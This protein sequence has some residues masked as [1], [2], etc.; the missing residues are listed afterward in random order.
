MWDREG[1]SDLVAG[2]AEL[3]S[4]QAA[5]LRGGR[6][7]ALAG[8]VPPPSCAALAGPLAGV[9]GGGASRSPGR[10]AQDPPTL[11]RPRRALRPLPRPL[12]RDLRDRALRDLDPTLA[13][14]ARL[15]RD[16]RDDVRRRRPRRPAGARRSPAARR[17][18][19][20][21]GP[22]SAAPGPSSL[23]AGVAAT[24]FGLLYGEFFGPT[25]VVPVLW[26]APLEEPV[27]LLAAGARRGRGAARRRPTSSARSTGGARAAGRCAL[28]AA[29]GIAGAALF[30]GLGAR[31]CS[32]SSW[33]AP[34][35]SSLGALVAGTRG[36][37]GLRRVPRG[38]RRRRRR[39][40]AG[41]DRAVR[42][43]PPAR[44][45]PRVLRPARGVRPDPRR[46]RADRVGRDRRACGA[47]AAPGCRPRSP[48][49]W[50]ATPS[51]SPS[52]RWWPACRPSGWSTTSCSPASSPRGPAVPALAR[53]PRRAGRRPSRAA[54]RLAPTARRK[55]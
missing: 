1:R 28:V 18:P 55:P 14:R 37:A 8:W 25:G 45:Q 53:P 48:S 42:H 47:A 11:L 6:S 26:L 29:S 24:V 40:H 17:P 31:A 3:E 10:V 16:V 15:R 20:A 30:A 34:G 51:P 49:S 19:R 27:T 2:E 50:S 43:G 21:A 46:A 41:D 9:G 36:R 38:H 32:V 5:A 4:Y 22:R 23:G 52:R 54:P 39:R 13:G 7:A 33:T 44:D 12:V 35:W